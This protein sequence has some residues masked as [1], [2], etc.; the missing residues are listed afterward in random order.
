MKRNPSR[1][2]I[3]RW[4]LNHVRPQIDWSSHPSKVDVE[5]ESND[6]IISNCIDKIK[7]HVI[8]VIKFKWRF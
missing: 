5:Q 2:N 7:E 4:I 8:L 1:K 3:V 6:S